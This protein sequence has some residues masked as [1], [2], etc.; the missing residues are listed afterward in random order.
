MEHGSLR[1]RMKMGKYLFVEAN[2]ISPPN[3]IDTNSWD[4][5]EEWGNEAF[6][7]HR[8]FSVYIDGKLYY[9]IGVV[10]KFERFK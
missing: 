5:I 10:E 3:L 7:G 6:H 9:G 2:E 8:R 4:L 1:G